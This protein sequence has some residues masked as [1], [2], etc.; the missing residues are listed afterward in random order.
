MSAS[1]LVT[2]YPVPWQNATMMKPTGK[3]RVSW[4]WKSMWIDGVA[5][6]SGGYVHKIEM[7][8]AWHISV[9]LRP[10]I[11]TFVA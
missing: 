6:L 3:N 9:D 1:F 2:A 4:T 11:V 5:Y 8:I 10:C 7:S